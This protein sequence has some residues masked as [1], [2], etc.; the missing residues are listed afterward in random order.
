[1]NEMNNIKLEK[2]KEALKENGFYFTEFA[3]GQ[4]QIDGINFWAT[5]EKYYNTKTGEKGHGL[6]NFISYLFQNVK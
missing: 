1:M 4:L 3:N 6:N 5:K 2:S